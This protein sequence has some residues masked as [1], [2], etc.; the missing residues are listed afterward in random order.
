M[1]THTNE[2]INPSW[3][4][5]TRAQKSPHIHPI[6]KTHF[7]ARTFLKCKITF[8]HNPKPGS[9]Q[10]DALI[11]IHKQMC[12]LNFLFVQT[13]T[14]R[15]AEAEHKQHTIILKHMPH[16][17]TQRQILQHTKEH[18][19]NFWMKDF[20]N[21]GEYSYTHPPRTHTHKHR[22]KNTHIPI[23]AHKHNHTH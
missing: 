5:A 17:F 18:E 13:Q 11:L 8:T 6:L 23:P 15:K 1:S 12:T 7:N 21:I 20:S 4:K 3:Q 10:L 9:T 2:R 16:T 14:H 22:N 19:R